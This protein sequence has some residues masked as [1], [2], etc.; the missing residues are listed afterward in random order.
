MG[1]FASQNQST[2]Q[3][4][5]EV[6]ALLS[7]LTSKQQQLASVFKTSYGGLGF[8]YLCS[9]G[10]REECCE[11]LLQQGAK[12]QYLGGLCNKL[13]FRKI[14]VE[15]LTDER[16]GD[17]SYLDTCRHIE[18]CRFVH[19]ELEERPHEEPIEPYSIGPHCLTEKYPAQWIR[20]DIRTFDFSIFKP[21]VDVVMADPPWDI[22]MDLPYGT[23]TDD[24]MRSLRV[25]LIQ[26][27]GLLFLWVTGRAMELARECLQL[28]GYRRVEEI[29]WI[30]TNQLQ[31]IIRTGRTG[32]WLNHSKEHCLVGIKGNPKVNRNIDCDVIVSEVRQTSRKPDEIY[33]IIERMRPGT[34]KVELF[35]RKHNIRNNWITL[36][37]QLEG[38]KLEEPVELAQK[39]QAFVAASQQQQQLLQAAGDSTDSR[40]GGDPSLSPQQQ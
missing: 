28:W 15:G 35:G 16:L 23:M 6:R 21:F 26:D 2:H 30:K 19:Y 11:A 5:S 4:D 10:T 40:G 25:D 31:R 9:Y 27:E 1:V 12:P 33:R 36:G 14:I 37:N 24:E 13:H 7:A 38:V 29:L 3:L 34:L 32:H 20:C 8:R 39:F 22:H 18:K 17:C